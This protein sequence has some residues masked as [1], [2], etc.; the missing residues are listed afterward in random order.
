MLNKADFGGAGVQAANSGWGATLDYL[1]KGWNSLVVNY[2]YGGE[3]SASAFGGS[4]IENE[5][6]AEQQLHAIPN[7]LANITAAALN[8]VVNWGA[9]APAG[10]PPVLAGA[11]L[12]GAGG[13]VQGGAQAAGGNWRAW[14][15]LG[16]AIVGA[17]LG[18]SD[19][20]GAPDDGEAKDAYKT[21]DGQWIEQEE[22]DARPDMQVRGTGK[23][24]MTNE[25]PPYIGSSDDVSWR[26]ATSRDGRDRSDVQILDEY[27][28][29]DWVERYT[30]EYNWV[31]EIG[32]ENLDNKIMPPNPDN[33][34]P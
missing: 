18:S 28:Q 1:A 23:I 2:I 24:S 34:V 4:I 14:A 29:G 12:G 9:P 31:N 27:L 13:G 7:P 10:Q 8:G 3:L 22:I 5:P 32:I 16:T 11:G 19:L 21:A 20:G 15:P 25:D 6:A 17:I 30:K 33:L 26:D